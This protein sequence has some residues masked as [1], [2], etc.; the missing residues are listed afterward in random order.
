VADIN[1][2]NRVLETTDSCSEWL[3]AAYALWGEGPFVLPQRLVKRATPPT[4]E[5]LEEDAR[6]WLEEIDAVLIA[7]DALG[8]SEDSR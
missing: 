6:V 8:V 2:L 7:Q 5:E 1:K 4:T 3:S